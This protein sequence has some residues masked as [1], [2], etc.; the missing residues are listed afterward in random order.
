MLTAAAG[1]GALRPVVWRP[2][3][4]P[5]VPQAPSGLRQLPAS[6][7]RAQDGRG[8]LGGPWPPGPV[9]G[10]PQSPLPRPWQG[11]HEGGEQVT[12]RTRSR[13]P[14][15]SAWPLEEGPETGPGGSVGSRVGDGCQAPALG[16]CGFVLSMGASGP[17]CVSSFFWEREVLQF[18]NSLNLTSQSSETEVMFPI[19]FLLFCDILC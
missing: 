10:C 8:A 18:K 12:S 15:R 11:E 3:S 7:R 5:C 19:K 1:H 14:G 2:V 16:A 17:S 6:D 4:A 9:G 13:N